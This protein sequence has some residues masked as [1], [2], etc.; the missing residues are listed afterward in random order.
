LTNPYLRGWEIENAFLRLLGH[1]QPNELH[2]L[3]RDFQTQH[4]LPAILWE[5]LAPNAQIALAVFRTVYGDLKL[6]DPNLLEGQELLDHQKAQREKERKLASGAYE[7]W[8]LADVLGPRIAAFVEQQGKTPPPE[9][10]ELPLEALQGIWE[11]YQVGA[12]NQEAM[13][14]LNSTPKNAKETR[15]VWVRKQITRVN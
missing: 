10:L 13:R 15:L 1:E 3:E 5:I 6:V 2:P 9:G 7:E 11:A 14:W 8:S 12:L 4:V